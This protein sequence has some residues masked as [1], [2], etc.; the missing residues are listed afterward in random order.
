MLSKTRRKLCF[1]LAAL[2]LVS[3]AM[4][5]AAP[6]AEAEDSLA[7]ATIIVY[8]V[9]SD[10]ESEG[11]YATRDLAEMAGSG[12]DFE[13]KNLIAAVGGSEYWHLQ[14]LPDDE[15]CLLELQ[16]SDYQVIAS[17]HQAN[18]ADSATLTDVLDYVCAEYPAKSYG[19]ILWNHGGGPIEGYGFDSLYLNDYGVEDSLTMPELVQ[20][21]HDSSFG[22]GNKLAFIGF[23]AC[24]MSSVEV[25]WLLR[26][27]A[28][29]LIASEE[30]EPGAGWDYAFLSY[31]DAGPLDG[32]DAGYCAVTYYQ[33]YYLSNTNFLSPSLSLS[34]LDLSYADQL[35]QEVDA[36][37]AKASLD[38]SEGAYSQLAQARYSA[39]VFPARYTSSDC[40]MVDL[41][42]L[43]RFLYPYYP[44]ETEAIYDTIYQMNDYCWLASDEATGMTIYFPLEHKEFFLYGSYGTLAPYQD[45]YA[46]LGFAP[47]Y[48]S[49]LEA[50]SAEWSSGSKSF[51]GVKNLPVALEPAEEEDITGYFLQLTEEQAADTLNGGYAVM[52]YLGFNEEKQLDGYALT[53][54]FYNGF[55]DEE[56]RLQVPVAD[57]IPWLINEDDEMLLPLFYQDP[58]TNAYN[59]TAV[60]STMEDLADDAC[61][62]VTVVIPVVPEED[63]FV[64][65]PLEYALRVEDG[66]VVSK[67]D[68]P[69]TDY[70]YISFFNIIYVPT[71]DENGALL[72]AYKWDLQEESAYTFSTYRTD[73]YFQMANMPIVDQ[74]NFFIQIFG[75]STYGEPFA[76]DLIPYAAH[77]WSVIGDICGTYWDV[78]FPMLEVQ[79]G[80]FCSEALQ[81]HAGDEFKVRF[82]GSWDQNC[83]EDGQDSAN[84]VV[85][86]TGTYYVIF[87]ANEYEV[88]LHRDDAPSWGVIGNICGTNWDTDFPMLEI[89]PGLYCSDELQLNAGEEFKVRLDGSW[90]QNYGADGESYY[91]EEDGIECLVFDTAPGGANCVVDK[92][93]TY[94][95]VFDAEQNMIYLV[96]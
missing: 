66:S 68:F 16:P 46:S 39:A 13:N 7:D 64:P 59:V 43:V 36:L 44:E 29:Y 69:I 35:E 79:P 58:Q 6:T 88:R 23:D 27:Y 52:V 31:L 77:T 18:M 20:A 54:F 42:D 63:P 96:P 70:P 37:F 22:P 34:C 94:F 8:M 85:E 45:V 53:S 91:L 19:L 3:L 49:F 73:S 48:V 38:L 24:M 12:F 11:G 5:P 57:Y 30:L 28:D 33:D 95:V 72:P 83:G 40:D 17:A 93:G 51:R 67:S 25:A 61:E 60:L 56:N 41:G 78:D 1:F 74:D 84:I 80:I 50:F 86:E 26:D 4:L 62:S 92:T 9:G 21:L 76:S 10:L 81:L 65:V 89:Q 55:V 14:G 32:S 87:D 2:M 75:S 15:L 47:N 71:Y 82:D 90:D